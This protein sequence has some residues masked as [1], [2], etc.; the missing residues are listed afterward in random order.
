MHMHGRHAAKATSPL[1]ANWLLLPILLLALLAPRGVDAARYLQSGNPSPDDVVPENDLNDKP[2]IGILSQPLFHE[3][4]GVSYLAASYVQ[5]V[6]SAGARAVP[7]VY[8][9]SD[10][11]NDRKFEAINGLI[12]P[13]GTVGND[14]TA[15]EAFARTARRF[16]EKA[17]AT[18]AAG[19]PFVIH[20]VCMGFQMLMQFSAN[21]TDVLSHGFDSKEHPNE[22][23][24]TPAAATSYMFGGGGLEGE[25][26]RERLQM[27]PPVLL[28]N[29]VEGVTPETYETDALLRDTWNV[30]STSFD[31]QGK[32]YLSTVENKAGYPI[33]GTQWHP[34][35]NPFEWKSDAIP[36][37]PAAV[38]VTQEMA[39][40]IVNAARMSSHRPASVEEGNALVIW[41]NAPRFRSKLVRD[42]ELIFVYGDNST[43]ALSAAAEWRR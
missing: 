15:A 14:A 38:T 11:V 23:H 12:L 2:L 32:E 21:R 19:D 16:Y 43:S 13:G 37:S 28:E 5:F 20:G 41:N 30:L 29:H 39:R 8:T 34:E 10:D 35:K 27:K 18:N 9:D 22:L 24:L 25:E 4:P 42:F 6:E 1:S 17:I 31:R 40:R 3:Q 33:S 36:H 26:L 7:I